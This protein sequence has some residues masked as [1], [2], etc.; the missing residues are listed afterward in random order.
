MR[1]RTKKHLM[2]IFAVGFILCTAST[3]WAENLAPEEAVETMSADDMSNCETGSEPS[4]QVFKLASAATTPGGKPDKPTL[5]IASIDPVQGK[6]TAQVVATGEIIHFTVAAA[7]LKREMLQVG[8]TI[9]AG[10]ITKINAHG[11]CRCGQKNDGSCWCVCS[12]LACRTSCTIG[13]CRSGAKGGLL[14]K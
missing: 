12:E 10:R 1:A 14:D 9:S 3:G 4:A 2:Y 8:Q 5:K 13:E 11:N 7:M 6:V